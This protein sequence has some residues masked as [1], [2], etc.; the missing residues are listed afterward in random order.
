MAGYEII[1]PNDFADYEFEYE[2][3]GYLAGAKLVFG[4]REAELVIYDPVRLAQEISDEVDRVGYLVCPNLLVVPEVTGEA[5]SKAVEY[6][7][8]SQFSEIVFS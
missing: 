1:F 8:H 6:L 4:E 2:A 5:I 3:K 7:S